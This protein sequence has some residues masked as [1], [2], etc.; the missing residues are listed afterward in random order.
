MPLQQGRDMVGS[1]SMTSQLRSKGF[2]QRRIWSLTQTAHFHQVVLGLLCD[3]KRAYAVL[4]RASDASLLCA[5]RSSS[6]GM[7]TVTRAGPVK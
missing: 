3:L 1:E 7:A 4:V 2:A 6:C 5:V